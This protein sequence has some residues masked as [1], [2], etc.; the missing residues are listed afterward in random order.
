MKILVL[1]ASSFTGGWFVD[2]AKSSGH[3][4]LGLSRPAWD[5][6]AKA[7]PA[8]S[9]ALGAGFRTVVNF[10]AMNVVPPSWPLA[11]EYYEANVAGIARLAAGL[12]GKVDKFVQ[13]STPEV[14]GT[15]AEPINESWEFRPSTPYAV[16]RAAADQHLRLMHENFGLPVCWTRTVN[17]Y[18]ERQQLHRIVP[19]TMVA[20]LLGRKLQLE[21]GGNSLRSFI[22]AADVSRAILTVAAR[23]VPGEVYHASGWAPIPISELVSWICML[24][25]KTAYKDLVEIVAERPGKDRAY[26]LDDAKLRALGWGPEVMLL[27]GLSR[28]LNWVRAELPRLAELSTDY[29]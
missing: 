13:V 11:A 7:S 1:G 26:L 16:S 19:K 10:A 5:L 28:T 15:T 23:G 17:V 18:G 21:G 29:A 24:V 3:E 12:A 22:Y 25:Q 8:L 27:D 2:V 4:V 14:Y 9:E 20:A 6:T